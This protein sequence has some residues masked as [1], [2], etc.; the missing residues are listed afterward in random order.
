MCFTMCVPNKEIMTKK[1][2]IE[3]VKPVMFGYKIDIDSCCDYKE[4][5]NEQYGSWSESYS[6]TLG[7]IATKTDKYP[8]VVTPYDIPAGS[9]ALVVW[10]EWS[11]GDSFGNGTRSCTDIIGMFKDLDSAA[12]L[13]DQ[14]EEHNRGNGKRNDNVPNYKFETP[15]G[16]VFGS[17]WAPWFGYF[18]CLE[19]V[20][21]DTVVVQ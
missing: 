6:N 4:H 18:E 21:V 19:S 16:Q 20:N 8:D 7:R 15:D 1:I 5:S 14:L 10:V 17:A 9:N 13:R 11:T 2:K 3:E 12:S